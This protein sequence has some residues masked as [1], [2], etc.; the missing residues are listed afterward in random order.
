L[1][2]KRRNYKFD[3]SEVEYLGHIVSSSGVAVDQGKIQAVVDWPVPRNLKA[4]RGFL[5]MTRYYRKFI[6]GYST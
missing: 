5:G 3:I 4:L 2:A 1:Y 6:R